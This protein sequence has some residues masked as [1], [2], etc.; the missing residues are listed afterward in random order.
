MY[1]MSSNISVGVVNTGVS[2]AV[3]VTEALRSVGGDVKIVSN[4][5]VMNRYDRLV[6]PG[7]GSYSPAMLHL[8]K[9]NLRPE[10]LEFASSGKPVLGICLGMQLF[11]NEGVENGDTTGLGIV[12]GSVVSISSLLSKDQ[13]IRVPHIGWSK[14][15]HPVSQ[16]T[17][18]GV[19]EGPSAKEFYFAHSYTVVPKDSDQI[20]MSFV[21]YAGLP[22]VA[23]FKKEN[24]LGVQFH[25]ELSGPNGLQFLED[26]LSGEDM[27]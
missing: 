10:I 6:I 27:L 2:N 11:M 9:M 20:R 12:D 1:A 19:N 24:I 13:M 21:N 17:I 4:S 23:A 18:N 16:K 15:H 14:V 25:P 5:G 8:D 22:L 7:V 26:F 3:H